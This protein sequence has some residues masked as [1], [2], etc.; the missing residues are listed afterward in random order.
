[1]IYGKNIDME[2]Y[3]FGGHVANAQMTGLARA[4]DWPYPENVKEP[5]LLALA[6]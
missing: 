2:A 6:D 5:L 1:M 4:A 3:Y